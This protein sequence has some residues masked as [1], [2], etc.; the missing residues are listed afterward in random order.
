MVILK[1]LIKYAI[2]AVIA[3]RVLMESVPV[4]ILNSII[5]LKGDYDEQARQYL[6]HSTVFESCVV[7]VAA[8][9][10]FFLLRYKIKDLHA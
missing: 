2:L 7:I 1:R 6:M 3:A 8:I 9:I 10:W 5:F 4:L